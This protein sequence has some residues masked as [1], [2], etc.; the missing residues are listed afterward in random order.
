MEKTEKD[1]P[2]ENCITLSICKGQT[3]S[4]NLPAVSISL[5]YSKCSKLQKYLGSQLGRSFLTWW[6][7]IRGSKE[8]GQIIKFYYGKKPEEV[9][10]IAINDRL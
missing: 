9:E 10:G 8:Y 2:C 6:R 7:E 3:S 4:E 5:L 1:L